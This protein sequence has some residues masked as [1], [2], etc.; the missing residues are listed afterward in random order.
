MSDELSASVKAKFLLAM[1][2]LLD[3]QS[4]LIGVETRT[5]SPVRII[6][7]KDGNSPTAAGLFPAGEGAGYS[8]GITSSAADGI[9]AADNLIAW[10]EK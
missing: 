1:P 9:K 4:V 8:G 5:S 3:P 10:L 6:R 7:Q 2:G